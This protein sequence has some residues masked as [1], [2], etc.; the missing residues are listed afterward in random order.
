MKDFWKDLR[1][2]INYRY[3]KYITY[4]L[5]DLKWYFKNMIHYHKIVSKMRNWD[6]AYVLDMLSFTLT[7][8]KKCL[9]NGHEV[10]EYRIPKVKRIERVLELIT[11]VREDNYYFRCGYTPDWNF[12]FE[13]IE[14][15]DNNYLVKDSPSK[16]SD[17]EFKNIQ[18]KAR[19]LEDKEMEE[20]FSILR[21]DLKGWWD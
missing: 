15:D 10:D 6:F 8:L 5:F 2:E 4:P 9:E 21:D 12:K 7:D 20:L 18:L 17:E 14:G 3:K 19:E 1:W 11:N 16:Y 13:K